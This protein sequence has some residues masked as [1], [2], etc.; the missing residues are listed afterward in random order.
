V[1]L[2]SPTS[3][4]VLVGGVPAVVPAEPG[5]PLDLIFGV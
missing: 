2:G 1:R 4:E 3:V 5:Q